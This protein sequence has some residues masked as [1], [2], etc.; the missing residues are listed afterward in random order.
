MGL[1]KKSVPCAVSPAASVAAQSEKWAN[2]F[3]GNFSSAMTCHKA[4]STLSI[5]QLPNELERR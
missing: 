5:H 1:I 2:E 3:F 4:P